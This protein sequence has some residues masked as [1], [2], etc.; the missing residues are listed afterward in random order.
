MV[1]ALGCLRKDAFEQAVK[2]CTELGMDR[3]VPFASE[4]SHF[5]D[6]GSG[7]FDRLRRVTL[8]A[9]KQSF[10][11]TLPVVEPVCGFDELVTRLRD[12][13]AVIVG[14]PDGGRLTGCPRLGV[15]TLIVGPE[16]GLTRG[17]RDA[18]SGVGS[19]VVSISHNRLR[20]ETAA[21]AL[22]ALVRDDLNG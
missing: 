3:C 12:S 9:M 20:S 10:R 6:Y 21:A 5:K 14:D 17:E 22:V 18:L 7:Y 19:T 2:Q 16:G 15:V 8:S 11:T 1:L 13:D 4:K